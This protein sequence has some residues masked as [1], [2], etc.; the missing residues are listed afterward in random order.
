MAERAIVVSGSA[1]HDGNTA[2]AIKALAPVQPAETIWLPDFRISHYQYGGEYS[3]RDQ[4]LEVINKILP[5]SM[6]VFATPVYWYSMSGY[7]KVFFDRLTDL[8]TIRKEIG[9]MMT[10]KHCFL[11]ACGSD[12]HLPEGFTIPFKNTCEY[13]GMAYDGESYMVT[14]N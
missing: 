4:F 5:C 13:L 8:I 2:K 10:G 1:K 9:R 11:I 12:N 6:V 7:M 3:E 14:R